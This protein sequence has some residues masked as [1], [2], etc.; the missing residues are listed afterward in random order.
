MTVSKFKL[1]RAQELPRSKREDG[2]QYAWKGHAQVA[3]QAKAVPDEYGPEAE[4]QEVGRDEQE[5]R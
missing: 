1:H 3:S 5:F 2:K 4:R